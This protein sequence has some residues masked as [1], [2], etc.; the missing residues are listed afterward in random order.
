MWNVFFWTVSGVCIGCLVSALLISLGEL[1][2][3]ALISGTV[4]GGLAGLYCG[5]SEMMAKRFIR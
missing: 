5:F 3:P 1:A 4:S 2:G